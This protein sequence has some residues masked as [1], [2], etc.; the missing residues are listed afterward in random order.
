MS[1]ADR[2]NEWTPRQRFV[3]AAIW[4]GFLSAVLSTLLLLSQAPSLHVDG[5]LSLDLLGRWFLLSWLLALI[6]IAMAMKL[7]HRSAS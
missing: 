7:V 5:R 6:P 2:R 1:A 4:M 3:A